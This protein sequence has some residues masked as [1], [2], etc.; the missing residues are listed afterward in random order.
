MRNMQCV[1]DNEIYTSVKVKLCLFPLKSKDV[2]VKG[3]PVISFFTL[4]CQI[5][6][7]RCYISLA[8]STVL[9]PE[10]CT[11]NKES[12]NVLT[13]SIHSNRVSNHQEHVSGKSEVICTQNTK[14]KCL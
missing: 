2:T 14:I 6:S 10:G 9:I 13:P 5:L 11:V 7:C 4:I 12:L 1:C 8:P 3:Y